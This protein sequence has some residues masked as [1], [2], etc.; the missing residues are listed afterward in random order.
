MAHAACG[1]LACI[2]DRTTAQHGSWF[3]AEEH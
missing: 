3:D 2:L 1:A